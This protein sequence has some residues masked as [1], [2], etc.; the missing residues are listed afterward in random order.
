MQKTTCIRKYSVCR[1]S[2][3]V[4]ASFSRSAVKERVTA[5]MKTKKMTLWLGI[6]C[7]VILAAVVVFLATSADGASP[8]ETQQMEP[9]SARPQEAPQP[10]AAPL[11]VGA[12]FTLNIP[13]ACIWRVME[14]DVP[15]CVAGS[16]E[17]LIHKLLN[18]FRRNPS[19]TKSHSNFTC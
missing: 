2:F 16:I 3:T 14:F 17:E 13:F 12:G 10:D 18:D 5:V 4:Y 7:V 15:L 1:L 8:Q 11:Y 9:E 6:V 19:S